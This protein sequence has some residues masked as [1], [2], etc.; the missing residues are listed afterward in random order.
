LKKAIPLLVFSLTLL[1]APLSAK[2]LFGWS[3]KDGYYRPYVVVK[4]PKDKM[5]LFI[6]KR[7]KVYRGKCKKRDSALEACS[8]S[9]RK[10]FSRKVP[11]RFIVLDLGGF[12]PSVVKTGVIGD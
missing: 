6:T 7:G 1:T 3:E 2:G 9:P 11:L 12:A 10:R 5:V 4:N 8:V